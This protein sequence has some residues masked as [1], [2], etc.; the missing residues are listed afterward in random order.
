MERLG[1]IIEDVVGNGSWEPISLSRN[2]PNL[3]DMF[4][5]DDVLLFC[6][7]R[8]SKVCVLTNI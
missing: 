3:S 7:A 6:K 8:P 5:A 2:S 1:Y 4:F